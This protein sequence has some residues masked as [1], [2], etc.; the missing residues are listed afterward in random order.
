VHERKSLCG[1]TPF[2]LTTITAFSAFT[3]LTMKATSEKVDSIFG[4]KFVVISTTA[5][6]EARESWSAVSGS[7]VGQIF[8]EPALLSKSLVQ[9]LERSKFAKSRQTPQILHFVSNCLDT[10]I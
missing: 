4:Q 10:E 9:L 1:A 7:K 5:I 8:G 3:G 2:F 6:V